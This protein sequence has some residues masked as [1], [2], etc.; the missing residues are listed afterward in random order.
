MKGAIKTKLQSVSAITDLLKNATSVYSPPVKQAQ[1]IRPYITVQRI[2][3][4]PALELVNPTGWTDDLWQLTVYADT[5]LAAE[6]IKEQIRI[7]LNHAN[8]ETWSGFTIYGVY[9]DSVDNIWELNNDGSIG[10]IDGTA[11][12]FRIKHTQP[13]S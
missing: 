10:S 6:A 13:Q 9:L 5:D 8:G 12:I 11:M 7:A 2:S 4:T 3:E 1:N